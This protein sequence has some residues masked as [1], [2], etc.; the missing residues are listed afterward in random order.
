M[1]RMQWTT[2]ALGLALSSAAWAG[3]RADVSHLQAATPRFESFAGSSDNLASLT[4]GLHSGR[5]ITLTGNGQKAVFVSPTRPMDYG[6][7]TRALDLAQRQLAAQGISNPTPGQLQTALL[8][9]TLI[10]LKGTVVYRGVLQM[11]SDGMGWSQI[12]HS[13]GIQPRQGK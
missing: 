1:K 9:G 2:F 10:T 4:R 6:D 5:Q 12:A 3:T 7:I 13:V 11:H 8:G